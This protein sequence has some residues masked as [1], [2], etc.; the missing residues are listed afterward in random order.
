MNEVAIRVRNLVK[1]FDLIHSGYS[2]LKGMLLWWKH[3]RRETVRA[4]KG[5]SLE[6]RKGEC[7]GVIGKNGAGKSTLLG[8]LARVYKPNSG[9]VELNGRVAPLL[10]L[11][12]GFHPDLTGYENVFFNGVILGLTRKQVDERMDQ[13]VAFSEIGDYMD[14]PVRTYS[15]GMVLRL[16]FSVAIHVDASILLVDE[17]L[18]VGDIEFQRNCLQRISEFQRAGGAILFVSH[19]M[20]AVRQAASRVIWMREGEVEMDG[21]T[22]EV[23]S[24]YERSSEHQGPAGTPEERG[25]PIDER[26]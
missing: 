14:A 23:V 21:P 18:A 5:V 10:E 26:R 24:A 17:A 16:G 7:V 1:E 4:L 22:E 13:I 20:R 3:R 8:V 15:S 11:G 6:V 12:A 25:L 9:E 2:S 19:D